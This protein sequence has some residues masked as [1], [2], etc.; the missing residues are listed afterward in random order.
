MT[1]S[2]RRFLCACLVAGMP[3]VAMSAPPPTSP[4]QRATNLPPSVTLHYLIRARQSGLD[5]EGTGLLRWQATKDRYSVFAESRTP[6]VGKLLEAGS[7]GTIDAFGLAPG[8]FTEK[9]FRRKETTTTF[10]RNAQRLTFTG[11]DKQLPLVGGEQDRSSIVWQLAAIARAAPQ[12]FTKGVE[13]PVVVAG[14]RDASPWILR[15]IGKEKIRTPYG[16]FDAMRVSRVP[17]EDGKD[18]TLDIW[19]APSLEWY[20]VRIRYAEP[21]GDTIEQL[22]T[23][24]VR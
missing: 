14:S 5:I 23:K 9:K 3:H 8:K 15:V 17:S 20:P 24:V 21:N 6:L 12:K 16:A 22:L 2:R 4:V 13:W 18:Q 7:E 10:D 1:F 19:L 11:S